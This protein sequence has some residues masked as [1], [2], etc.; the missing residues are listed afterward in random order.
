MTSLG[1]GKFSISIEDGS[2]FVT[3]NT[4]NTIVANAAPTAN[5]VLAQWYFVSKTD[6][7]SAFANA[8]NASPVD[9][10]F[11]IGDPDFSR[12]HIIQLLQNGG[13]LFG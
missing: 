11:Y 6:R 13:I 10:T 4:A 5:S 12:N 9:A 8:T 3:A 7:E 1:E 2:V